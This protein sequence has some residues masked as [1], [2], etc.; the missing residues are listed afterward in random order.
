MAEILSQVP[1][2]FADSSDVREIRALTQM[3]I[4]SGVTTNPIIVANKATKT[5]P[6]QYYRELVL[7]FNPLPVSIQLPDGPLE[8]LIDQTRKY[9]EIGNNVVVKVPMYGDGRGLTLVSKLMDH[10]IKVNVTGLMSAQQAFLALVAGRDRQPDYL[11]LF[12]NRIKDSGG[13]PIKEITQTRSFL[14][15]FNSR[16][17]IITGSIRRGSDV[18]DAA[19]A[20]AHIVTVQPKIIRDMVFHPK[21]VEFIEECQR[22][23]DELL[24]SQN[25]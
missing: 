21:S 25:H 18:V 7:E 12:F 8:I 20:G 13:D 16:A 9:S 14:D 17:E 4:I 23:W 1:K 10:E 15:R 3:G 19:V 22:K 6:L 24:Q 2:I 5:D 11:S